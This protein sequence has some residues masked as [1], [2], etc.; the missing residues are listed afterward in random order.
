M[1]CPVAH[2]TF[3]F[4]PG[5]RRYDLR[6]TTTSAVNWWPHEKSKRDLKKKKQKIVAFPKLWMKSQPTEKKTGK[7]KKKATQPLSSSSSRYPPFENEIKRNKDSVKTLAPL[8]KMENKRNK[9][10]KNG[11]VKTREITPASQTQTRKWPSLY[12][13]NTERERYTYYTLLLLIVIVV[14]VK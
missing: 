3:F 6:L 1:T 5:R 9:T 7:E 8:S 4:S 13:K 2:K 10:N 14:V 12:I 11:G